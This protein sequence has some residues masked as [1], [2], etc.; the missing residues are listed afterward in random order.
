MIMGKPKDKTAIL[1]MRAE[2]VVG[3]KMPSLKPQYKKLMKYCRKNNI[4]VIN[5]YGQIDPLDWKVIDFIKML[6]EIK[7]KFIEPDI[8]LFTSWSI[9]A[10]K[11]DS[12]PDIIK[13]L[14]KHKIK[15]LAIDAK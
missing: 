6:K 8:L 11:F 14:C 4:T 13:I 3:E 7:K 2:H 12:V 9:I 1:Y 5:L 10:P 15:P